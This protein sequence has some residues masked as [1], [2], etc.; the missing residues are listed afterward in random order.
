MQR[1]CLALKLVNSYFVTLISY[2]RET[3]GGKMS[4]RT[5]LGRTLLQLLVK[6]YGRQQ[7]LRNL[8]HLWRQQESHIRYSHRRTGLILQ[9]CCNEKDIT[10]QYSPYS[11]MIVTQKSHDWSC[12]ERQ[13]S[14][15]RCLEVFIFM[16]NDEYKIVCSSKSSL[17]SQKQRKTLQNRDLRSEL[18][19]L[20]KTLTAIIVCPQQ[21]TKWQTMALLH[22]AS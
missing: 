7:P 21:A 9:D 22:K 17:L 15:K 4:H 2:C 12:T 5:L 19:R 8:R 10:R 16:H 1:L 3:V 13:S 20:P 14:T 18:W 11:H 6:V